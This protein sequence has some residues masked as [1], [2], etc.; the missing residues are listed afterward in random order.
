VD[1]E[2]ELLLDE[3]LQAASPAAAR[4]AIAVTA[5]RWERRVMSGLLRTWRVSPGVS[6]IA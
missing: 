4:P 3:L 5:I 1:P 6:V 2:D